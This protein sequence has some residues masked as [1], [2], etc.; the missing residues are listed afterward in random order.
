MHLNN[1]YDTPST[2]SSRSGA[3]RCWKGDRIEHEIVQR[4]I[5]ERYP[6]S[7]ASRFRGNGRDINIHAFGYDEAPLAAEIKSRK[8]GSGFLILENWLGGC[9]ALILRRNNC[10]PIVWLPWRVWAHPLQP[11]CRGTTA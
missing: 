9:D 8:R 7:G 3:R 6:P 11:A 10:D 4:R 1:E 2:Y 5:A